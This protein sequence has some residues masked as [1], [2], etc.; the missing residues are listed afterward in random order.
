LSLTT[1]STRTSSVPA[2]NFGGA[3]GC[4]ALDDSTCRGRQAGRQQSWLQ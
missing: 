1:K 3:G 4:W 2:V